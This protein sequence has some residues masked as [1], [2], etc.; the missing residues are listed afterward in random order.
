MF[1]RPLEANERIR[2]DL[3]QAFMGLCLEYD[4]PARLD[5][6]DLGRWNSL[7]A[8][9]N[10]IS[11]GVSDV[12]ADTPPCSDV[13]T[14]GSFAEELEGLI[15][16]VIQLLKKR[17][18]SV[19][20]IEYDEFTRN[21][22]GRHI[23]EEL[24]AVNVLAL[25]VSF[26]TSRRP[27]REMVVQVDQSLLEA[28]HSVNLILVTQNLKLTTNYPHVE[29][30]KRF[31]SHLTNLSPYL[32]T[33]PQGL[34]LSKNI[35]TRIARL[36]NSA[37]DHPSNGCLL[38]YD[39]V[40]VPRRGVTSSIVA[41]Y[42]KC[43]PFDAITFGRSRSTTFVPVGSPRIS[44]L[45]E[46]IET[47]DDFAFRNTILVAPGAYDYRN[48]LGDNDLQM[49]VDAVITAFPAYY[50]RFQP[51]PAWFDD[52]RTLKLVSHFK[53]HPRF[54]TPGR[55]LGDSV[56]LGVKALITDGSNISYT[57]SLASLVPSI[58]YS[59]EPL[60]HSSTVA[61][62][63]DSQEAVFIFCRELPHV[64]EHLEKL[65]TASTRETEI[66]AR[67]IRRLANESFDHLEDGSSYL[68]NAIRSMA[69][70]ELLTDWDVYEP[71]FHESIPGNT[72][73]VLSRMVQEGVIDFLSFPNF[74]DCDIDGF[75]IK[76]RSIIFYKCVS[77][78]RWH[79]AIFIHLYL[80][81]ICQ[82]EKYGY[83]EYKNLV[84][85]GV[86][87]NIVSTYDADVHCTFR[88]VSA[89]ACKSAK[90]APMLFWTKYFSRGDEGPNSKATRL[91][92]EI[93]GL[94][95]SLGYDS[96]HYW[97]SKLAASSQ[98]RPLAF[99][100]AGHFALK[101]LELAD[102]N[103]FAPNAVIDRNPAASPIR[104]TRFENLLQGITTNK[105]F[106]TRG[107]DFLI[108][109]PEHADEIESSL[110]RNYLIAKQRIINPF[111]IPDSYFEWIII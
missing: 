19:V 46:L 40:L 39:F 106:D 98:K 80:W 84:L 99:W 86:A 15:E 50:V 71:I 96:R 83:S 32:L 26:A 23:V 4:L 28:L 75:D 58:I 93:V 77:E 70:S 110:V 81:I 16:N 63:G 47:N 37:S 111:K 101:L 66:R 108:T 43:A 34:Q 6:T 48:A 17:F 94:L 69:V 56:F 62:D 41:M 55:N 1:D 18:S 72:A 53:G 45:T 27:T 22:F 2:I 95:K 25:R 24:S 87:R 29:R 109:S 35:S 92:D 73:N 59:K 107:Y 30:V 74:I 21:Y 90:S 89:L 65:L 10:I 5:T 105:T 88:E 8:W 36:P 100:G 31:L 104:L 7:S 102:S 97:M 49:L 3:F 64:L 76:T 33:S 38:G 91:N 78:H 103:G 68:A 51:H 13:E 44:R 60:N 11:K 82:I 42:E 85:L 67:K 14:F 12:H 54:L 20:F 57:Y 61:Q 9:N 79:K 52:P